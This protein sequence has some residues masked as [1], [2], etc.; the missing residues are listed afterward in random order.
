MRLSMK[1]TIIFV[2]CPYCSLTFYYTTK[3]IETLKTIYLS[4]SL[5]VNSVVIINIDKLFVFEKLNCG[6]PVTE[7]KGEDS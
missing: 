5:F 2:I 1:L 3:K 6:E 4:E 7:M